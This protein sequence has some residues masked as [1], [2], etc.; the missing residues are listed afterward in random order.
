[1]R[2]SSDEGKGRVDLS[3]AAVQIER[4]K[5]EAVKIDWSK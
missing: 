4:V 1:M 5:I 3:R 2:S